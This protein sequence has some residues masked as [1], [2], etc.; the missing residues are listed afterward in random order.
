MHY[1]Y[2]ISIQA[3]RPMMEEISHN[4]EKSL[5]DVFYEYEVKLNRIPS[6]HIRYTFLSSSFQFPT[7][8]FIWALVG[9][10]FDTQF[11]YAIFYA[12][13]KLREQEVRNI[14]WIAE[15]I[16]QGMKSKV[17]QFIPIF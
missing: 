3:Y 17:N 6:I 12:Y 15:C 7:V 8:Y 4:N 2:L 11:G 16:S 9:T 10:A 14:V 13:I 5:E 1:L